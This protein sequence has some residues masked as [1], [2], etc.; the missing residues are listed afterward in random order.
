MRFELHTSM[1][2]RFIQMKGNMRR[3]VKGHENYRPSGEDRTKMSQEIFGITPMTSTSRNCWYVR[4]FRYV[5]LVSNIRNRRY[6]GFDQHVWFQ[7]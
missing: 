3:T 1:I 6:V 7:T 2:V 5:W 4:F